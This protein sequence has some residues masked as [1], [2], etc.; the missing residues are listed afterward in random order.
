MGGIPQYTRPNGS[1]S[2]GAWNKLIVS[3]LAERAAAVASSSAAEAGRIRTFSPHHRVPR[4]ILTMRVRG[5]E[6][7]GSTGSARR[8]IRSPRSTSSGGQR[9]KCRRR[10]RSPPVRATVRQRDGGDAQT[11]PD[12]SLN[13]YLVA[14]RQTLCGVGWRRRGVTN[15]FVL[16]APRLA[17]GRPILR[18]VLRLWRGTRVRGP[19]TTS[20]VCRRQP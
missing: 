14:S 2:A 13:E 15:P 12:G 18:R 10:A 16:K 9:G 5:D 4:R 19:V 20:A 1:G 17:R 6:V 11:W 3:I 7:T 8:S